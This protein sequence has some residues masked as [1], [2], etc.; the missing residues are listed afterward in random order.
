[1][2]SVNTII[3][4]FKWT[5]GAKL[6]GQLFNWAITIVVIRLLEP[7]DYGIFAV[8]LVVTTF[9]TLLS[10]FGVGDGLIR[11]KEFGIELLRKAFGYILIVNLLLFLLLYG[12][13]PYVADFY[14]REQL[15]LILQVQAFKFLVI[16]L[17]VIPDAKLRHKMRFKRLSLISLI[18]SVVGGFITLYLALNGFGVWS[19]VWG[20]LGRIMVLAVLMQ[21]SEPSFL[22][23]SFRIRD[24]HG[25]GR[26]GAVVI[27]NRIVF[28]FYTKADILIIGKLLSVQQTGFYTVAKDL[29][30]LPMA[31]LA[32]SINIVGFS[33]F[34]K[35]EHRRE[36]L[37]SHYL[38]AVE[39][40][41][42]ISFPVFVGISSV[43]P[44]VVPVVLGEKWVN[45]IV[46]LQIISFSVPFR[47][48]NIVNS[49]LLEGAGSPVRNLKNTLVAVMTFVPLFVYAAQW[50]GVG[51]ALVW[52]LTMP[53]YYLYV[54]TTIKDCVAIELRD[55]VQKMAMPLLNSL[56]MYLG[57]RMLASA[58]AEQDIAIYVVILLEIFVGALSYIALTL[59]F[60]RKQFDRFVGIV[61]RR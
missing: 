11:K 37:R 23:P 27:I 55:V 3:S 61:I 2:T 10:E 16:C 17:F 33:A 50:G 15:T 44:E 6:S 42:F 12:S 20:N 13:A 31:K 51:V 35:Y 36:E 21:L 14:E 59:W 25:I 53:L 39:S 56:F 7:E 45:V 52:T 1:M 34:S 26:F 28:F 46:V 4:G 54:I 19:L 5:A 30:T 48:L 24:L 49:P 29:A 22:L 38:R 32:S 18:A 40:L 43:A 41:A 47:V 57:V 8:A 9:L 58:L 60:N